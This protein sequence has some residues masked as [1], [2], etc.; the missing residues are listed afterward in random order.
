MNRKQRKFLNEY[1][2]DF[3]ATQAAKRAGYAGD[4]NTLSTIGHKLLRNAEIS[5]AIKK[6]MEE[7]AMAATEA[8]ARLAKFARGSM[9]DFIRI[10]EAGNASIDLKMAENFGVLDLVKKLKLRE[11]VVEAGQEETTIDRTIEIELHDSLR[12][13]EL[14]CRALGLFKPDVQIQ[15]NLNMPIVVMNPDAMVD[16]MGR[17]DGIVDRLRLAE[18]IES[19]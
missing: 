12:A 1:L 19:P 7:S 14:I 13:L 6:H 17:I 3:N 2:I 16:L 4:D 11:R 10:D 18:R 9:A 8:L 5:A 15:N